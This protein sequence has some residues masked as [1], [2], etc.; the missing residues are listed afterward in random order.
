MSNN[1][2]GKLSGINA[3][4]LTGK[5]ALVT[6]AARGIGQAIALGMAEA[7][8]EVLL[9]DRDASEESMAL[10]ED[11]GGSAKAETVDLAHLNTIRA[12]KI[13]D[14][15]IR[16]FGGLDILVN[17]AGIIKR[18]PSLELSS[19]QWAEVLDINL[20]STFYLSQAAAKYF[21]GKQ[22]AGKIINVASLL[23]FQGGLNVSSYTASKSG[24]LG[25]TRALSN[26]WASQRINVNAIAPG[27]L[28]TEVTAGIRKDPQRSQAILDRIPSG[29]WGNPDDVKGSVV[30]LASDASAYVHGA[31]IPIDGGWL[32]R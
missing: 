5:V 16:H 29:R 13:I 19:H 26:E 22:Q 25:L 20:N 6:G 21:I 2:S 11:L 1:L 30:Y 23:S 3:F 12:E 10:I 7:G 9:I 28:T 32:A 17:N 4:D 14:L 24:I 8:A 15:A 18:M 27:Y 31:V